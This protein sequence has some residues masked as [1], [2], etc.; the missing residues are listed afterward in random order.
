[1]RKSQAVMKIP[2]M[3]SR[4]RSTQRFWKLKRAYVDWKR[5]LAAAIPEVT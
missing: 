4:A 3:V 2:L 5:E 1:M